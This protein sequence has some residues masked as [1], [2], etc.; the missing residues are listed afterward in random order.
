MGL[1]ILA[2]LLGALGGMAGIGA[3]LKWW[4]ERHKRRAASIV[5]E[6]SVGPH[7]QMNNVA[8]LQSQLAYLEKIIKNI[9]D[10]NDK[11]QQ[12][13]EE[14]ET[15]S[16]RQNMRIRELEEEVALVRRNAKALQEQCDDLE[17]KLNQLTT[18]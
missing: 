7:V 16:Q 13:I 4:H 12:E 9:S 5:A 2:Q 8:S 15:R 1:E 3:V 18:D 6:Q 17:R 14:A 10:H 11:L